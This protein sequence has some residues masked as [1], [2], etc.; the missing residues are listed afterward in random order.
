MSVAAVPVP[1]SATNRATSATAIE[2]VKRPEQT[3]P[4]LLSPSFLTEEV[5]TGRNEHF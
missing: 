3:F 2:G 5:L 1:V 4:I